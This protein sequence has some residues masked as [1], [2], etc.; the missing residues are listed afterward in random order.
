MSELNVVGGSGLQQLCARSPACHCRESDQTE[1]GRYNYGLSP[2]Q[3]ARGI[4]GAAECRFTRRTRMI[5]TSFLTLTSSVLLSLSHSGEVTGAQSLAQIVFYRRS[6]ARIWCMLLAP[7]AQDDWREPRPDRNSGAQNF[8]RV[9][10]VL[11]W[12]EILFRQHD[13]A[14]GYNLK[15]DEYDAKRTKREINKFYSTRKM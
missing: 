3:L 8:Q 12:E 6:L 13:M 9:R 2:H 5:L 11:F 4:G 10:R 1:S 7:C 14:R 15:R